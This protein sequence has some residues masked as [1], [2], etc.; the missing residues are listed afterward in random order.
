MDIVTTEHIGFN[1]APPLWMC[2]DINSCFATIEQQA[3]PLLRGKPVAVGAYT[4]DKG[5][6]LAASREAKERGVKTGMPVWQGRALAP[7]LV[8]LPADP[9]KYRYVNKRMVAILESYT[10]DIEVKS[11]DEMIV[12]FTGTPVL[13]RHMT[14]AIPPGLTGKEKRQ[15]IADTM[16][17]VALEIKSRIRSEIGEWITVSIGI[18]PN[19]YLAKLASGMQKPDGLVVVTKETIQDR[20]SSLK[21]ED[22]TGIKQG[23][24][25]R[26]RCYGINSAIDMYDASIK[27]LSV[28]FHS[29]IGYQWWLRLHGWEADDRPYATRSFGHSYALGTPWAPADDQLHQVVYQLICKMGRRLRREGYQAQGVGVSCS[30]KDRSWWQQGRRQ[31]HALFADRDFF[32]VARHLLT[33]A[34]EKPLHI[35]AVRCFDLVSDRA[36]QMQLFE[37][38]VKRRTVTDAVDTIHNRWGDF[39]VKPA[40]MLGMKRPVLDRIAF[41]NAHGEAEITLGM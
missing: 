34:P 41:G 14:D 20:L 16:E 25:G 18:A 3:N 12:R 4:T 11:I 5:C 38:D 1:P 35:I 22:L 7:G 36:T 9:A 31:P 21:L 29:V 32:R 30:Y 17:R 37:N 6:I 33:Q 15:Q 39:V 23:Y 28:A 24:G 10:Q 19:R 27:R 40:R 8:V 13:R 2:V 26:L